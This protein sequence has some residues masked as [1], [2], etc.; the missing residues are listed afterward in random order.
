MK[1]VREKQNWNWIMTCW[2]FS[3]KVRSL[4]MASSASAASMIPALKAETQEQ[5][6]E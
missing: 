6:T 3:T 1:L 5:A 2:L 4:F